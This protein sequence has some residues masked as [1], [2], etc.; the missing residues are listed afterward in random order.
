[1]SQLTNVSRQ[2]NIAVLIDGDNAQPSL[3]DKILLEIARYGRPTIR[4]I[5]GDWTTP[6][7]NGWKPFL[8]DHA[9]SPVQQFRNTAGKNATDST[10]IIDAM[11]ILYSQSVRSFCVVSSDSDYARL[12]T[13]IR[14]DGI[15]FIGIGKTTTPKVF[16]K[17]CDVFIYTENLGN[18][19]GDS[20]GSDDAVVVEQKPAE[21]KV[22]IKAGKAVRVATKETK[23]PEVEKAPAKVTTPPKAKA[24]KQGS[25]PKEKPPVD[26]L[27]KAFEMCVQE[28]GWAHLGA[29][30]FQLRQIDPAFDSRTWGYSQLSQL[31]KAVSNI[32]TVQEQ[33]APGVIGPY[34]KLKDAKTKA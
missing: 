25:K 2:P 14:E 32:F 3:L 23:K 11:D 5:Y 8:Q 17:A 31:V 16:V 4:R 30:G 28:D 6:N 12:A 24:A 18:D 21:A 13:R 29:L 34:V 1:M 19:N 15:Q 9:V 33:T 26:M 10:L 20:D 27:M 7:M 22:Q